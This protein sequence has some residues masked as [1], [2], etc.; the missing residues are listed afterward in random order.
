MNILM[1]K[2]D[3]IIATKNGA[4]LITD[5]DEFP[6]IDINE[7]QDIFLLD[8]IDKNY[9]E[10]NFDTYK[11]YNIP[12]PRVSN[13]LKECINKEYLVKWAASIGIKAMYSQQ[14]KATTIGTIVHELIERYLNNNNKEEYN[15]KSKVPYSYLHSIEKSFNNFLLWEKN[16]NN[17]GYKIEKI[18]GTEIPISCPYYGGTIDCIMRINGAN[19]IVDFKTSKSISFEYIIQTC[20]YLWVINNGY[21]NNIP[22]VDGIGI[23][24]VDKQMNKF[25]DLFLNLHIPSQKII[26]DQ[27][28]QG[29]GS[30]LYSYYNQLNMKNLFGAYKKSYNFNETIENRRK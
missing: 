10:E 13:I 4:K 30:L 11:F 12:V 7:L 19:Y 6:V 21:V 14:K 28:I 25:E 16:L 26:I 24:R 23:I 27:Y 29:F 17:L 20:A 22:Y 2:F 1:E 15:Y 18:I 9:R 8:S 3:N 5:T